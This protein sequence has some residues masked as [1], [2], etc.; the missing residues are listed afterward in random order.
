ML[1]SSAHLI[2]L[3]GTLLLGAV[4]VP[5]VRL[6][7][8]RTARVACA[9]L[10]VFLIVQ[11]TAYELVLLANHTFTLQYSLPL[12]LCD[13]VAYVGGVA[14]ILPVPLLVELTW[15]W[16]LAGTLQ[17]LLTPDVDF[18]FP[19]WDWLQ[20]YGDHGG[21]VVAALVLVAGRRIHPRRG[22][23]L[24]VFAITAAFTALV[25]L[26]DVATGGNYMYLRRVPS[27]GSLLNLLGPWP[28]YIAGATGLALLFLVLLDLPFWRERR[29]AA[30]GHMPPPEVTKPFQSPSA[31]LS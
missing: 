21:V 29:R 11:E 22:A 9:A 17:G 5:L 3:G 28:W 2:A 15:F 1:F 12:F 25:G 23:A 6:R 10:G 19:S 26:V 7:P 18:P 20:F 14:L 31:R 30:D 27:E 16:G 8:G 24:R 4:M 13:V